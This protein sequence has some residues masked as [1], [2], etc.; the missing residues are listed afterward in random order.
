MTSLRIPGLVFL[1]LLVNCASDSTGDSDGRDSGTSGAA[2][3]GQGGTGG[4][5]GASGNAGSST[6]GSGGSTN[7]CQDLSGKHATSLR[8]AGECNPNLAADQCGVSATLVD[9]CG[10]PVLVNLSA[11]GQLDAAEAAQDAWIGAGCGPN[12]CGT[13]CDLASDARCMQ[14]D[15]GA[16]VCVGG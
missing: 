5:G 10:C 15:I 4:T 6:G 14:V 16:G 3:N 8:A 1:V 11:T 7:V 13:P 12:P 9:D 2:G